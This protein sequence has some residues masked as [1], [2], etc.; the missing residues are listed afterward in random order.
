MAPGTIRAMI[1]EDLWG[2]VTVMHIRKLALAA[3]MMTLAV[4]SLAV[5]R[6]SPH[7]HSR[8][9]VRQSGIKPAAP[10]D[11]A[12]ATSALEPSDQRHPDD[13]ALDRRIKSICRGC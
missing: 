12:F 9:H 5:A 7:G 4:S 2:E 3:I 11:T 10:S 13:V 6:E 8:G 1:M